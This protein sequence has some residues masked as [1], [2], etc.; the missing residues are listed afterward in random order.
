MSNKLQTIVW[1]DDIIEIFYNANLSKKPYLI[2]LSN[3]HNMVYEIRADH[4]DIEELSTVLS[5]LSNK[6]SSS[7]V[8][9]ADIV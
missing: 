8:D 6:N 9:S 5:V 4:S 7:G 2:R 1:E 3:Y